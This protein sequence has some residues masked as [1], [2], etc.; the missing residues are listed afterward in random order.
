MIL[1]NTTH[2]LNHTHGLKQ[3]DLPGTSLR[4]DF[5]LGV[6]PKDDDLPDTG[7]IKDEL[8]G[9]GL[10]TDDLPGTS[11]NLSLLPTFRN[12]S[13]AL[14][15]PSTSTAVISGDVLSVAVPKNMENRMFV[16][17]IIF[18]LM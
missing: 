14:N 17:I 8:P 13:S 15:A 5:F 2:V 7:L 11:A 16:T 9:I 1:T 10:Q 6:G 3:Y 4:K 12:P 18:I